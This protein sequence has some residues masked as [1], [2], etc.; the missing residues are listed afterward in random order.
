MWIRT[1]L[2]RKSSPYTVLIT[3]RV[4]TLVPIKNTKET[5]S[6]KLSMLLTPRFVNLWILD[7]ER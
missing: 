4:V 3:T 1:P 5:D 6:R 2:M 7:V